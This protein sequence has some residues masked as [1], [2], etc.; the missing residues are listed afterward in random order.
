MTTSQSSEIFMPDLQTIWFVKEKV[1][2]SLPQLMVELESIL[3]YPISLDEIKQYID[4]YRNY[5][6]C[7]EFTTGDLTAEAFGVFKHAYKRIWLRG[8]GLS[9][10]N[11]LGDLV[12]RLDISVTIQDFNGGITNVDLFGMS[13]KDDSWTRRQT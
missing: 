10:M 12:C 6:H 2:P 8:R 13:F 5:S 9:G 3:G 11:L 1:I 4:P 7:I